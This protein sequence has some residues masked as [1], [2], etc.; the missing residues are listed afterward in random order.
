MSSGRAGSYADESDR[1]SDHESVRNALSP[2]DGYF[3]EGHSHPQDVLVADPSQASSISNKE[4]EAREGLEASRAEASQAQ[5]AE[6]STQN[7]A[8]GR[9]TQPSLQPPIVD[10]AASDHSTS[11]NPAASERTPLIPQAPPAYSPP[12]PGSPY[13]SGAG[14][15]PQTS[16]GGYSTMGRQEVFFPNRDPEDLGGQEPLLGGE[17]RQNRQRTGWRE[18]LHEKQNKI[19]KSILL[20]LAILACIGFVVNLATR[21]QDGHRKA[22]FSPHPHKP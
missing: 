4:Q 21:Y 1:E 22:C 5:A 9:A 8:Q 12:S 6:S 10:P 19:L 7:L 16:N 3:N 15:D 18:W 13:H 20:L 17:G 14:N 11:S 2:T